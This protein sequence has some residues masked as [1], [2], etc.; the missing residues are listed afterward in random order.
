MKAKIISFYLNPI[1][2]IFSFLL[3]IYTISYAQTKINATKN[4]NV[5][6]Y[7]AMIVNFEWDNNTEIGIVYEIEMMGC[8]SKIVGPD[9]ISLFYSSKVQFRYKWVFSQ[10]FK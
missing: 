10:L 6:N 5:V 9:G 2:L 4:L 7:S 1:V 3:L 8:T